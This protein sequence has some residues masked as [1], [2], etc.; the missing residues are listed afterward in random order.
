MGG[1]QGVWSAWLIEQPA[2]ER[3][4]QL[5]CSRKFGRM[6]SVQTIKVP[7]MPIVVMSAAP[8]VSLERSFASA[9]NCSRNC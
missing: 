3:S 1:G 8:S 5:E 4:Q 7:R 9:E 2:A 6:S